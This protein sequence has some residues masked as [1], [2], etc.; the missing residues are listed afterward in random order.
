MKSR[1]SVI[2]P[3]YNEAEN[4]KEVVSKLR[5]LKMSFD[6]VV[7][8]DGST[9]GT[10]DVAKSLG[11]RVV[12]HGKNWGKGAAIRTGIANSKGGIVVIQDADLEYDPKHIPKLLEPIE[13]G[14]ADVVYGSRFL[15]NIQGMKKAHLF[16]NWFLSLATSAIFG[17][18]ITDMETGYKVFAP[19]VVESLDLKS[20]GFDIE[21]EIT[22]K[23][24]RKNY[25]IVELPITFSS[26]KKGVKKISVWDGIKAFFLLL[27]YAI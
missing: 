19:G 20:D 26:R 10:A 17:K 2:I 12:K 14:E 13:K 23:I 11:V 24:I 8:D 15:G 16:G 1:V 22:A 4:I 3:A 9:D 7:V 21:P 27:K 18:R 6:I 5:E 25:R